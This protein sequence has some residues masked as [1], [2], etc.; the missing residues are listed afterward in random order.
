MASSVAFGILCAFPFS[1]NDMVVIENLCT[2]AISLIVVRKSCPLLKHAQNLT[3]HYIISLL[4]SNVPAKFFHD[5]NCLKILGYLHVFIG[6]MAH[7]RPPGPK[8]SAGLSGQAVRKMEASV[9]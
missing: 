2:S 5:S 6:L 9:K 8:R 7:L 4:F 3:F 1:T